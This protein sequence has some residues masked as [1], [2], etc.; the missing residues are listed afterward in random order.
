MK[1]L[2][3]GI[4][5]MGV[6][7]KALALNC[8]GRNINVSVYNR[9]LEGKEEKIASQFAASHPDIKNLQGFDDLEEFVSSLKPPRIILL[10][11]KAGIAVDITIDQLKPF[12]KH[13]DVL[14]DGGN[15]FYKDSEKRL[16]KLEEDD[17]YYL[18]AGIS[19]GEEGALNGPSIMPGGSERGYILAQSILG[20]IAAKDKNGDPCVEYIGP[21]GAGHYVKMVHNGIEYAEMQLLAEV[22]LILKK[23]YALNAKE[24][25][26][27]FRE[28]KKSG[29]SGFLLNIT[30]D[31][32]NYQEDG[33]LLLEKV[34]DQSEQKGTGRW[35]VESAMETGA[36]LSTVSEAVMA[37]FISAEKELRSKLSIHFSPTTIEVT[38]FDTKSRSALIK[39]YRSARIIN[40]L[41]A[42]D[43][44]FKASEENKWDLD[45]SGIARIWTNGC[46]IRSELMEEL[47]KIY[48]ASDIGWLDPKIKDDLID[49]SL[50]EVSAEAI[51]SGLPVPV[52]CA[53]LNLFNG[54]ITKDSAANLIQAQRDYFGAHTYKRVDKEG[55]FHSPWKS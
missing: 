20:E 36:A 45:L 5:G 43:L 54:L 51:K 37:R 33:H 13:G 31:I 44:I 25:T 15:S 23:Q 6:M 10:M 12:L 39:A 26:G 11:I 29:L 8:A 18:G 52:L 24:I 41:S 38:S 55:Y 47:V 30:I 16:E 32:L 17:I 42:F 48:S 35:T 27:F 2:S 34:L 46:I 3:I 22:Y 1:N 53:S 40:H 7:G 21:K 9:Y 19:G 50:A 4:V 49:T 28:C 14:I